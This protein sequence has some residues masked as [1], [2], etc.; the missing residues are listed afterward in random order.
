[1][2]NTP[3]FSTCPPI[4]IAQFVANN[5]HLF[6]E[7]EKDG[8]VEKLMAATVE[9]FRHPSGF[10]YVH[11]TAR[12]GRVLWYI[13]SDAKGTARALIQQIREQSPAEPL[14]LLCQGDVR[15]DI[16]QRLGFIQQTAFDDGDYSMIA[17]ALEHN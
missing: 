15:R 8:Q 3:N 12:S 17:P 14:S 2:L 10:A 13:Y 7:V 9:L 5:P 16:F 1:M 11:R 6:G 4:E